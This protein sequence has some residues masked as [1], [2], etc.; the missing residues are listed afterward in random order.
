MM[1]HASIHWPTDKSDDIRLW[2]FAVK[3]AAWLYNR[4]PQKALGNRSPLELFTKTKSDHRELLRTHVWGC[5]VFV[6]DAKL[7]D[8][9]KIPKF[10]RR[11]RMG[12]FLGFSDEHLSLVARVH[13]LSTNF[14]S[15][16]FHIIFD[17][18]FTTI[19]NDKKLEDTTLEL[20][21]TD[22]F[23]TCRDYYGEEPLVDTSG[24]QSEINDD[25]PELQNE[26]LNEA[27]R[28]D[29]KARLEE[30]RARQIDKWNEQS[31]D[32]EELNKNFNPIY[33]TLSTDGPPDVPT[34]GAHPVSDDESSVDNGSVSSA[35]D[36]DS[37]RFDAPEGAILP[38]SPPSP[39]TYHE[40]PPVQPTGRP[41]RRSRRLRRDY[42]PTMVG[43]KKH[44]QFA[45]DGF[46]ANGKRLTT[47]PDFAR[48]YTSLVTDRM[49]DKSYF[50][51]NRDKFA[52]TLGPKQPP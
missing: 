34:P 51:N 36:D 46:M 49:K 2:A 42:D 7:Q 40:E 8:G 23:E 1:V 29:K 22:L 20:I 32:T 45:R 50:K 37:I 21:F 30:R 19:Q 3:H 26:W 17:D 48:G 24:K 5:P 18:K 44:P 4:L 47:H 14:V 9:K 6:L 39:P 10:N 33:P 35:D 41:L 15:P 28:R 31:A 16:Q 52:M 43:L 11:A 38:P 25:L 12:Q 13:N 27:E